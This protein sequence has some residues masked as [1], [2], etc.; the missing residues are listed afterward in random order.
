M[1]NFLKL[2]LVG[3]MALTLAT[4]VASADAAKGQKIFSKKLKADCGFKGSKFTA[5]HSQDEWAEIG[6]DGMADEIKKQCP[7]AKPVKEKYLKDL[8]DF[9]N[10]FAS[11][12]GNIPAC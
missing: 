12:S 7:N 8:F 11:D 9:A 3:S 5:S 4:T 10:D 1:R 2:V 6:V